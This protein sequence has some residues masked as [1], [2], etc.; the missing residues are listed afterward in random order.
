M[1]SLLKLVIY[2]AVGLITFVLALCV[3]LAVNG[4]L[5]AST[6]KAVP[7]I[8]QSE[9]TKQ[10]PP[11]PIPTVS[12][13]RY[14]SSDELSDMLKETRR[15][16]ERLAEEEAK[17]A[18]REKRLD[19]LKADLQREKGEL[20]QMRSDLALKRE[21]MKQSEASYNEKVAEIQQVELAGLQRSAT[22]YEA[23]DSKKAAAA[24]GLLDKTQAAKLLS[25]M[26]EKKAARVLGEMQSRGAAELMA[27]IK[28]IRTTPE[29]T[30]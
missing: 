25:L 10:E 23:M 30:K 14:F 28:T 15:L 29:T 19:I 21:E 3:I 18:D 9:A 11:P 22:I 13:L 16:K 6:F 24:I 12:T 7:L 27:L 20:E 17:L 2:P 8:G 1:K 4:K 26:D 5:N